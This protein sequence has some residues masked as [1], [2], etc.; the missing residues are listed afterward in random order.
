V[1][2]EFDAIV[3]ESLE[4]MSNDEFLKTYQ[5]AKTQIKNKEFADWNDL[6]DSTN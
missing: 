2:G 1:K 5:E 6:Q 4:L 3:V